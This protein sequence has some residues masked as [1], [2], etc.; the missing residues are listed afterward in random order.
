M[1]VCLTCD[2]EQDCPPFMETFRGIEEGLPELL[3]LLARRG[4]AGTFFTTGDVARRFPA[5]I[6]GMVA[7]GHE[8]GCHGDTHRRF[9]ACNEQEARHEI[10]TATATLRQFGP[11]VSFRAE[12]AISRAL[13]AAPRGRA[14]PARFVA[15]PLQVATVD[16]G[17]LALIVGTGAGFSYLVGIAAA[18]LDSSRLLPPPSRT[19]RVVRASLGI[20]RLAAHEAATRLSLSDRT[21][22]AGLPGRLARLFRA[23]GGPIPA[24]VR[25]ARRPGQQCGR[26]KTAERVLHEAP[27]A[28]HPAKPADGGPPRRS[29]FLPP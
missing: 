22:R 18:E 13:C 28:L 23:R 7:Q 2:V 9:D 15:S 4:I 8:L 17:D 19:G 29:T 20:R 6:R 27:A 1:K 16:G 5:A 24:D 14:V 26:V 10:Q 12:L 21:G 25:A 3:A 11:V